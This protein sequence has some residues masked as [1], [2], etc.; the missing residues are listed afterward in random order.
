MPRIQ[1]PKPHEPIRE[2]G[3]RYRVVLDIAPQGAKRKQVTRTFDDLKTARAFVTE[4]RDRI[5]KGTFTAPSKVTLRELSERWLKSRRNIRAKS[6]NGYA[7]VLRPILA[8]LGDRP[9]QAINRAEVDDLV[10]WLATH[11]G[12]KGTG[13]SHRTI[14]YGLGTLKQVLAYGVKSDVL[15]TNVAQGVEAP[16]LKKGD[17]RIVTP[18]EPEEYL[19]FREVADADPLAAVW[20]LA[21]CGLRRS[22]VLG[23]AWDD[24]D[25]ER[26]TV[27]VGW[28]RVSIGNGETSRDDTK[29]AASDRTIRPDDVHPGT[30]AMLRQLK[31]RQAEHRLGVGPAYGNGDIPLVAVDP[32]GLPLSPDAYSDR[33]AGLCREAGVPR[34]GVHAV[35]HTLARIMHESGISPGSAAKFLG[36]TLAVHLDVYVVM[37]D[38]SADA[39]GRGLGAALAQ[40]G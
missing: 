32:L 31:A 21:L 10:D 37:S 1:H 39:A 8:R 9:A 16:R 18:W 30:M 12:R 29:S 14:V 4:T 33:F 28:S 15:H 6:V 5:G 36:H 17:R 24:V 11:G 13:Y 26:G 27:H 23:L 19:R 7:D 22:E 34:I 40:V 38:Q 2:V 35:R 20:R 25:L 3:T